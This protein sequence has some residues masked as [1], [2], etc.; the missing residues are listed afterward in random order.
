MPT[1]VNKFLPALKKILSAE[2][3]KTKEALILSKQLH[4]AEENHYEVSPEEDALWTQLTIKLANT[5]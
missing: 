2:K 5:Y 1:Y 3:F 4:H